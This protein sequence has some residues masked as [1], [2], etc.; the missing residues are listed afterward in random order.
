MSLA[1]VVFDFDGV[2][3]Q[4]NA[5]KRDAY[6]YALRALPVPSTTIAECLAAPPEGDRV[7]IID[8][9]VRTLKLPAE[10]HATIVS[11]SVQAYGQYCDALLAECAEADYASEILAQLAARYALYVNSAT[12]Q[13]ALRSYI[14]GRRW[15]GFFRGVCGRPHTKVENFTRI[16][17][18]ERITP[19]RI[20]FVGD[21]QSDYDAAHA[22]GCHFVGVRSD[23]ADFREGVEV[24]DSLRGLI[25]FIARAAVPC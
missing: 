20:L 2:L 14:E 21:R 8:A 3:V 5:I 24:L 4:S 11:R 23:G 13:D 1:C 6:T 18:A 19:A 22:A 9:I 16:T 12:P 15:T 7:D 10:E 17:H 25:G